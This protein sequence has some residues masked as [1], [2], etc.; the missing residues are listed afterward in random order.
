[1]HTFN[2]D[3]EDCEAICETIIQAAVSI[4]SKGK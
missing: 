4:K 1:M 2:L 3:S